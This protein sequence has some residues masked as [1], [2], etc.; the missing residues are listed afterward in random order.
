VVRK[1]RMNNKR[2][3]SP[4]R[5]VQF[6]DRPFT[7]GSIATLTVPSV[8]GC[9]TY[10]PA[11]SW[12]GLSDDP[13]PFSR[14]DAGTRVN[15]LEMC[16]PGGIFGQA[17]KSKGSLP[18]IDAFDLLGDAQATPEGSSLI[19]EEESFSI[20]GVCQSRAKPSKEPAA[21]KKAEHLRTPAERREILHYEKA[22]M[23]ADKIKQQAV[24]QKQRMDQIMRARHPE[25]CIGVD[26]PDTEG[27]DV[28]KEKSALLKQKMEK[29]MRSHHKRQEEL[30]KNLK[31]SGRGFSILAQ[32][33]ELKSQAELKFLPSKNMTQR[34]QLDTHARLFER[35]V[36]TISP[37]R[38]Q[39]QRDEDLGG[40]NYNL[41]TGTKIEVAPPSIPERINTHLTHP[42]IN[43]GAIDR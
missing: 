33:D 41:I 22:K 43:L 32:S 12:N 10:N 40:K 21:M 26:S 28:Y 39:K 42:S 6:F 25:G 24:L 35:D 31:A 13:R 18:T 2:A 16:T 11:T 4:D 19:I 5:F 14:L 36:K 30:T 37:E 9:S 27:S 15:E 3:V 38:R 29:K 20:G 7:Q 8:G 23:K 34:P 1:S 17:P